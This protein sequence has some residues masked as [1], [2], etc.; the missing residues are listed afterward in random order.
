MADTVDEVKLKTDIVALIG[1]HVQ[2]KKAGRNF[3]GLCPFHSEKTPSFMVSP[4]LQIYKCFGCGEGGDA[5]SFLEKHEGMD[6][7]EA[8]KFLADRAG[9]KLEKVSFGDRGEKQKIYEINTLAGRLY[10][11]LL[12]NHPLGKKA[13]AYLRD[14]R[15]LA[16]ETIKAFQ[17][18]FSPD[19][20]LALSKFLI[21]KKKQKAEDIEKSGLVY[22]KGD[23]LID[24]LRGRIIFPLFDHRGNLAGFAGR[25]MPGAK[26]DLAKYINTPE[27]PAY[28]KSNMLY[29]LN[30]T[31]SEIKEAGSAIVVEGELDLISSWQ[32]GVKNVVAL[33]GTALTGEQVKLIGRFANLLILALDS[34]FAGDLAARRGISLA[35]NAGLEVR[36][37]RLTGA[38]DP[39]EAV[40]G[41]LR[42]Y[43]NSL[44]NAVDV[45]QFIIDST[46]LRNDPK[47]GAGKAKISREL[48]PVLSS[49]EDK[50]VQAHYIKMLSEAL[51]VPVSS[52]IDEV[53]KKK[54]E[55]TKEGETGA[56][57]E[58]DLNAE[59]WE[60]RFLSLAFQFRPE[61]L[62]K[63]ET[64]DLFLTPLATQIHQSFLK[65]IRKVKEFEALEFAKSLPR[66]LQEGFNRMMLRDTEKFLEGP[67]SLERELT[68]L[69]RRLKILRLREKGK[70]LEAKIR[71]YEEAGEKEKLKK[72][73]K[74]FAEYS[75]ILSEIK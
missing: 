47:T 23:D 64:K 1:E 56:K 54:K 27:T 57:A 41:D 16:M 44:K 18:G 19:T 58:P 33:K 63:G 71:Q 66:Q 12:L 39:A 32:A 75:R 35:Q 8:L 15:G 7:Y 9:V 45:W 68:L 20:P 61:I 69:E 3:K 59:D 53:G 21:G 13:L 24:R 29:G 37:A 5:F 40:R 65:Y 62:E 50:I 72:A 74:S 52:V 38:K 2:L 17:L 6:F 34:D 28:H 30:M 73:E 51:D 42:G 49:I 46:I 4:E 14:E 36:V 31:R 11:Y 26:A 25:L 10:Q 22:K 67:D 43:I 70:E 48:A 60:E 55:E